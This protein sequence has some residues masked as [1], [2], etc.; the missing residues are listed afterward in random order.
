M[1]WKGTV[2]AINAAAKKAERNAKKSQRELALRHKEHAKMHELEQAAYDVEFFENYI[3]IVQSMHKECGDSINWEKVAVITEPSKPIVIKGLELEAVSQK[4]QY[5]P[6]FFDRLFKRIENKLR[7][8]DAAIESAKKQDQINFELSLEKWLQNYKEWE[9]SVEQAN[10]L[11]AGDPE[12]RINTIKELNPFS[13][14]DTL[15]SSLHF[16]VLENYLLTININIRGADIIPNEQKSLLKSGKLSV[17][18][19]P[20][21]KFNELYQDYVCSSVLRVA[22]ETFAILPDEF[23]LI[24]ATDRLLNKVTGYL[25]EQTILSVYVSRSTLNSLNMDLIDPSDS[26]RNFIHNMSFKPT[27]GFEPVVPVDVVTLA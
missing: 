16:S 10:L 19:M 9:E 18:K 24:N 14:L 23:V 15:G 2:R 13:E 12:A 1:G 20:V 7:A 4:E 26:M 17:K 3:E 25:E 11:I 27:K 8:L 5:Q 21:G 22:R 6:S